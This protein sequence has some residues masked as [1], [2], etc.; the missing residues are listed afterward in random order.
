M[1]VANKYHTL[2]AIQLTCEEIEYDVPD[3]AVVFP[4]DELVGEHRARAENGQ[5]A[6]A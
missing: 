3:F 5:F 1:A 2:R 4:V 6:A